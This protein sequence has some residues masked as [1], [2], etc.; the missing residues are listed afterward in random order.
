[1]RRVGTAGSHHVAGGGELVA[2]ERVADRTFARALER[3]RDKPDM[4]LGEAL[5]SQLADRGMVKN[6]AD[7]Y[8]LTKDHL[9]SLER[10][11]DKSAQNVLDEIDASKKLPLERNRLQRRGRTS[12]ADLQRQLLGVLDPAH[13]G[14]IGR[15]HPHQLQLLSL[16]QLQK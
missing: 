7:L 10:M 13:D 8:R 14:L 6:V 1:M 15:Q 2:V 11:G 3:Q 4:R 9:L 16:R 12:V 5:V